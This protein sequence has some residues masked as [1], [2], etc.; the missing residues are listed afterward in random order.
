MAWVLPDINCL[1]SQESSI[2]LRNN[3]RWNPRAFW[4]SQSKWLRIHVLSSKPISLHRR[5]LQFSKSLHLSPL[6]PMLIYSKLFSDKATER[7]QSTTFFYS[8]MA[9]SSNIN[10]SGYLQWVQEWEAKV[11]SLIV[12]LSL[13]SYH[14]FYWLLLVEK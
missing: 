5:F 4:W 7:I 1:V 12:L 8:L 10:C 2:T 6:F 13:N 14:L 3:M 11:F 9:H